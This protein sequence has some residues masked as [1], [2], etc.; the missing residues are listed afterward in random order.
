M[1]RESIKASVHFFAVLVGLCL[2]PFYAEAQTINVTVDTVDVGGA[3]VAGG[4]VCINGL[5]DTPYAISMEDGQWLWFDACWGRTW[6]S[7]GIQVFRDFTYTIDPIAGDGSAESQGVT[8]VE[9]V[10]RPALATVD[11]VDPE[12]NS[13]SGGNIVLFSPAGAWHP[14]VDFPQEMWIAS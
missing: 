6:L 14:G 11:C 7:V 4:K 3:H 1:R 10:V 12:G 9:L 13:Q 8:S 5:Q 2:L